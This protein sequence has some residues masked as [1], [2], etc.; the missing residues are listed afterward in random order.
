MAIGPPNTDPGYFTSALF[1]PLHF[2]NPSDFYGPLKNTSSSYAGYA[3]P[4]SSADIPTGFSSQSLTVAGVSGYGLSAPAFVSMM[5]CGFSSTTPYSIY[6]CTRSSN[7]N[8]FPNCPSTTYS[9][10]GSPSIA[11]YNASAGFQVGQP[12][13]M[14]FTYNQ[15]PSS[16]KEFFNLVGATKNYSNF[17]TGVPPASLNSGMPVWASGTY[18][19]SGAKTNPM[20]DVPTIGFYVEFCYTNVDNNLNVTNTN[21]TTCRRPSV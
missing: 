14:N 10:F 9:Q 15:Q 2:P 21:G 6:T 8:N 1:L 11:A 19:Y 13:T 12:I 5:V 16:T 17:Y 3:D 7:N 20:P 18:G 4:F